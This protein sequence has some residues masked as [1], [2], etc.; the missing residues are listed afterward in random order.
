MVVLTAQQLS[1]SF[2]DRTL[3]SEVS[4]GISSEDKIGIIGAN[5]A[6]KSTL[7]NIIIGQMEP[8]V[9][10]VATNRQAH[11]EL[12]SQQPDLDDD[13]FALAAVLEDGPEAF[14]VLKDYE[15]ACQQLEASPEDTAAM[16]RVTR[17][18]DEMD[19]VDG[20]SVEGEARS[21]LGA[22]G[23]ENLRQR[24]ADMSGGQ[25]KRLA[26]ARALLRPSDLLILDEPTNHLDVS[27]IEWLES[28]LSGRQGA[29]VLITHDRYFLDRVT[30]VI[31]EM[32][33]KTLFRHEGNYSA[34]LES[35]AERIA[36]QEQREQRRQQLAKK[37][38]EWLRR[39]PKARTTKSK[40]RI[41]RANAL[42]DA[43]YGP[44]QRGEVEI[45]T[46]TSR[47]GKKILELE[48]IT[49]Q[50]D[51][52]VVLR[53]VSYVFP[54]H[55]RLGIV[56]PNG[57]GKSTL[58]NII[59]GRLE[60]DSGTLEVGETVIFGYYDQESEELDESQRVHDY[61]TS[62]SN[63]IQTRGGDNLSAAQMLERFL[64]DRQRQWD[65]I[66]KLS[67]GERRRLYL[68]RV[69]MEQ[70]N[71]LLLDEPTNDLDVETLTVLEDY[72]E[73]FEGV[74]IVV[75]HD[76][77]F[78]DR[79][80]DHLL[81]FQ[82]DNSVVEFPGGYSDWLE[83]T[84]EQE[85]AASAAR[86]QEEQERQESSRGKTNTSKRLSYM[87]QRELDELGPKMAE[88]EDALEAL[89]EE[90]AQNHDDYALLQE[91]TEKKQSL[92]ASLDDALERWMELEEKQGNG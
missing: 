15:R 33:E 77:Y 40:S 57:A 31:F 92:A 49:K 63:K 16:A 25:R 50:F 81:V 70:P 8:D 24:V 42:L 32:A 55:D 12:L 21:L 53:D 19:R 2:G 1:K 78:L 36:Q 26:L 17:L 14:Q 11:I 9:G 84:R 3:F 79:T 22:L 29:L 67:G 28:Y 90:M 91:L 54:R 83:K 6:G 74:V 4:F 46:L 27:T 45:D 65:P 66:R 38:L 39:G 44:E 61:I 35:R 43:R 52:N 82:E 69:L 75:S 80:V 47:L 5:G 64:F 51:D 10:E 60:A 87:E 86:K 41:E 68:L 71:V 23:I 73:N 59:S 56:G 89:D 7:L 76:R 85:A 58:L 37:E 20:W 18:A 62:A 72:L 48:G 88:L 13:A 30:N 34:F